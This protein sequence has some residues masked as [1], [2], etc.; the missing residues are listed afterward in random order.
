MLIKK[1]GEEKKE[2][3]A[4]LTEETKARNQHEERM[5]ELAKKINKLK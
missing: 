4:E 1:Y 2:L 5:R 3:I